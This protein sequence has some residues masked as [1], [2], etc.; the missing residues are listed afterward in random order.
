MRNDTMITFILV[1][2]FINSVVNLLSFGLMIDILDKV[3]RKY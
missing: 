1:L 3:E 2:S